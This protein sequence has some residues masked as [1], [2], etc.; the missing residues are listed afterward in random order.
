MSTN[1]TTTLIHPHKDDGR[2]GLLFAFNHETGV[3]SLGIPGTDNG[4][5]LSHA[6]AVHLHILLDR[7][8]GYTDD[9][10][11]FCLAG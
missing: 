6:A 8:L 7:V 2:P 3:L 1:K 11:Y 4:F 5:K 10:E 9:R